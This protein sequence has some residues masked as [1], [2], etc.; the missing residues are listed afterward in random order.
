M[1]LCPHHMQAPKMVFLLPEK[2][3]CSN[4]HVPPAPFLL[5][6]NED[7]RSAGKVQDSSLYSH[8]LAPKVTAQVQTYC[9]AA[10]VASRG[11][12]HEVET[13]S[14]ILQMLPVDITIAEGQWQAFTKY[15]FT[16]IIYLLM[17]ATLCFFLKIFWVQKAYVPVI[18]LTL[19]SSQVYKRVV[20]SSFSNVK[21]R[22]TINYFVLQYRLLGA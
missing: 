9:E 6:V 11:N 21:T 16:H 8:T 12:T 2:I 5:S 1:L 14:Y 13:I 15:L 20:P 18:V 10:S 22:C 17:T 7:C 19:E 4:T 3:S